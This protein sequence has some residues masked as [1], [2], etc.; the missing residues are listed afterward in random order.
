MGR[1]GGEIEKGEEEKVDKWVNHL[2]Q[3][4]FN[5]LHL[6]QAKNSKTRNISMP[7]KT[8]KSMPKGL[9]NRIKRGFL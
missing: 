2:S 5:R 8:Q 7:F 4:E 6:Q 3:G 1:R 9:T